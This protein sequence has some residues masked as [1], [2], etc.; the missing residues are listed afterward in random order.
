MAFQPLIQQPE[1]VLIQSPDWKL[2]SYLRIY[3]SSVPT[4][5]SSCLCNMC[6]D[7]GGLQM[8]PCG[9]ILVC[10]MLLTGFKATTWLAL[11]FVCTW[12]RGWWCQGQP[13]SALYHVTAY[14]FYSPLQSWAENHTYSKVPMRKAKQADN[15]I[16]LRAVQT[17]SEILQWKGVGGMRGCG[18][19]GGGGSRFPVFLDFLVIPSF[20]IWTFGPCKCWRPLEHLRFMFSRC[21]SMT[22]N[23]VLCEVR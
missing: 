3:L 19:G 9:S 7:V 16:I 5:L 8:V 23:R 20:N 6:T 12:P 18:E 15:W 13:S 14:G 4:R 21:P 2:C 11:I 17:G 10:V 1:F 22:A